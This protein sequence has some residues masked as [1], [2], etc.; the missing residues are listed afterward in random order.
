MLP[1]PMTLALTKNNRRYIVKKVLNRANDNLVVC[2]GEVLAVSGFSTRHGPE[3][4][5]FQENVAL[6][7][8]ERDMETLRELLKQGNGT[9]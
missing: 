3:K 8:A 1:E 5:F 6:L 7:T 4:R 9:L 2:Y